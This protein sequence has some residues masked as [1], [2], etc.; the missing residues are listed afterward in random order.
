MLYGL[1]AF[2]P[3]LL[4]EFG[5]SRAGLTFG[6]FLTLGTNSVMQFVFGQQID[7]RGARKILVLG[8]LL[9]GSAYIL[10]HFVQGLSAYYAICMLLGFG[11]S[12]M[13]YV[14]N[15]A[16]VS[17]W[18][19]K[20]RGMALGLVTA[21]SAV[22]GAISLPLITYLTLHFGWRDAFL[23]LGIT[24]MAI[25]LLPLFTIVRESPQ[26]VG[27]QPDGAEGIFAGAAAG[28][29]RATVPPNTSSS[30]GESYLATIRRNPAAVVLLASLFLLGM[31]IGS[32]LQ[33]LILYLRGVGFA[34]I[35]R[36]RWQ[37]WR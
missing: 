33:H 1:P 29:A 12:A 21:F 26:S 20:Q 14:P 36:P 16:L 32:T 15:S 5:W 8:T 34:P 31:F 37:E 24:C 4:S 30:N 17:R 11:W 2:Y 7:R 23:W 22:G 27:L 18:F 10:F 28:P 13:S 9:T 19:R 6:H 3:A 35:S 25:P